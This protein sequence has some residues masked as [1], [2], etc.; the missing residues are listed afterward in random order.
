MSK[1]FK[2]HSWELTVLSGVLVG[3]A[4]QPWKLG[5]L[6]YVGFVPIILVWLQNGSIKNFKHGYLFG[7][8][9]NLIS[10]YW[11][12]YN[13]GAEFYVVMLSLLFAAGYLALFWGVCGFI[14]GTLEK[15]KPI[16]YLPFLIVILEWIRSFGPLGFDWGVLALTQIEYLPLLQLNSI[17][18]PYFSAFIIISTNLYI[19]ILFNENNIDYKKTSIFI[20]SFLVLFTYGTFKNGNSSQIINSLNIAVIQPNLDPKEKWNQ[21]IREQNIQIIDS[22]YSRAIS[23]SPD[24]IL[25]PETAYPTYLTLDS[26][27]R[28]DIQKKVN[29]SN[30]PI[31]VG[32]VDRKIDSLGNKL[33]FNSTI[34][35]KPEKK[36][37]SYSKIHLVP[38]AEYDLVPEFLHPLMKLNLNIDRGVFV[39]GKELKVFEW[40]GIRFSDLICY[41]SSF[42][43]YSREFS[44]RGAKILMIQANDGWLGDSAGPYQHFS[45][46]ILRA[47]ENSLPIVR[48]GNTGI[49]GFIYPSG[50]VKKYRK[51]NT[52]SI[53]MEKVPIYSR[54]SFYSKYGDFFAVISF[55]IF[56]FLGPVKCAKN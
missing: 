32:T 47:I 23:L 44:K 15:E 48:S 18:G 22:L 14:I 7:F 11:I 43:R 5:F 3:I 28:N 51:L 2:K 53:F 55:V 52:R 36:Y 10:N 49:S 9:Y 16:Y 17:F 40:N 6:V 39:K 37:D 34:F 50:I 4:Y 38:F 45:S 54:A 56:L 27:L 41:E 13:S 30:I 33:F 25:F 31:L 46:A 29:Q 20:F 19:Y 1:Y 42:A 12:G 26:R 24:F 21:S 8:I 35:M